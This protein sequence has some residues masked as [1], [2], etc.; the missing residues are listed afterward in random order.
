MLCAVCIDAVNKGR[1]S[2][3]VGPKGFIYLRII[4]PSQPFE[5]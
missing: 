5:L 1:C 3:Q 4:Q 2:K